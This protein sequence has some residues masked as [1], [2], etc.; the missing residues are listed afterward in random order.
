MENA[1]ELNQENTFGAPRCK[2]CNK[3]FKKSEASE[4]D[5]CPTCLS[6]LTEP[7]QQ[8][9]NE[10]DELQENN[11]KIIRPGQA[12]RNTFFILANSGKITD[13]ILAI[14]TDKESTAKL[15]GIRYAFLKEF[16]PNIPIKEMTYIKGCAR[17][18]SKPIEINNKKY[19]L[20]NDLYSKNIPRFIELAEILNK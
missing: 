12:I 4:Y 18:S 11:I 5:L 2:E 16:S 15:L 1:N 9:S 20:T 8:N 3:L 6:K 14:L 19:L 10:E 13:E 17:Y 7:E